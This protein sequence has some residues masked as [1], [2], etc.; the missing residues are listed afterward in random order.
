MYVSG[1]LVVSQDSETLQH[2]TCAASSRTQWY[3][4]TVSLAGASPEKT[5]WKGSCQNVPKRNWALGS[6]VS[7]FARETMTSQSGQS[8][9]SV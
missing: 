5:A 6:G 9:N 2:A 8:L 7:R 1:N 4:P 3:G